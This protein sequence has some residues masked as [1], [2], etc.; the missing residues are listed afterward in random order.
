MVLWAFFIA[1]TVKVFLYTDFLLSCV[2]Y[3]L[4]LLIFLAIWKVF[5]AVYLDTF[6]VSLV[7]YFFFAIVL[8]F[9]FGNTDKWKWD[10]RTEVGFWVLK[11]QFHEIFDFWFFSGI[12][13]SEYTIRAVSNF[14]ENSWRY[15]QMQKTLNH[16]SF[17]YLVWTPL[18]SRVNL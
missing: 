13:F 2:L 16:K 8:P 4:L 14:F 18:E 7:M 1:S 17:N 5:A 10:T 6:L 9:Y 3:F 11:G 12:S 15:S